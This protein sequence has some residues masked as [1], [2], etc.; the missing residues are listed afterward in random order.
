[1]GVGGGRGGVGGGGG[2]RGGVGGGGG[3]RGGRGGGGGGEGRGGL[4]GQEPLREVPDLSQPGVLPHGPR[5]GSAQLD[6]VVLRGVVAGGEHGARDAQQTGGEVQP[7]SGAQPDP[8]HVD[9]A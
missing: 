5:T 6:A 2:G 9:A 7:V 1:G 8:H 3:G 4:R